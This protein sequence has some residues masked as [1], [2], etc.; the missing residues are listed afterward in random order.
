[1]DKSEKSYYAVIGNKKRGK[2]SGAG[3]IQVAKKVASKKL[4]A[5]KEME[6]YLDEVAGKKK[7]FGP[8]QARKDKKSGKVAVVKGRKVMKGGLLTPD[9]IEKLQNAF[10]QNREIC[11]NKGQQ[12]SIPPIRIIDIPFGF[13]TKPLIFFNLIK[14]D[15]NCGKS[16]GGNKWKYN[17]AVFE[18]K[19][20][21]FQFFEN[22]NKQ[23]M[24]SNFL[25]VYLTGFSNKLNTIHKIDSIEKLNSLIDGINGNN[26]KNSSGIKRIC[27]KA[28]ELKK[29]LESNKI[30]NTK[31]IYYTGEFQK[32]QKCVY[33]D[34]TFGILDEK[35]KYN[36]EIIPECYSNYQIF[37]IMKQSFTKGF[38]PVI[39]L[40]K[41]I[42]H[43]L[44]SAYLSF[45]VCIYEKDGQFYIIRL[46]NNN[47]TTYG[48]LIESTT[49]K[50][51]IPEL[52]YYCE[53]L[54]KIPEEFGRFRRLRAISAGILKILQN[55]SQPN[56]N[57]Q[58]RLGTPPLRRNSESSKSSESSRSSLNLG[59]PVRYVMNHPNFKFVQKRK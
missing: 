5:G 36:K 55:R 26:H 8:Y 53:T 30:S 37:L 1:M 7:R 9:D 18:S 32:I 24:Y 46:N 48:F 33:P 20:F 22:S 3:P 56:S 49:L 10:Q 17:Y 14:T 29:F 59:N 39:F 47:K 31:I 34:L 35:S 44:E 43:Q 2:F 58:S 38:E 42:E 45:D 54:Q 27:E 16:N 41:P 12:L 13:K 50:Q 4:K 40:R 23:I 52:K 19:G 15:N 25:D 21:F 57:E 28:Q 51:I 6:F 11:L